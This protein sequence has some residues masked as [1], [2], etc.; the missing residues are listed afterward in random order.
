MSKSKVT[1]SLFNLLRGIGKTEEKLVEKIPEAAKTPVA[2]RRRITAKGSTPL[3]VVEYANRSGGFSGPGQGPLFL[4]VAE[5]VHRTPRGKRVFEEF[6]GTSL[7]EYGEFRFSTPSEMSKPF[8][9]RVP[10]YRVPFY[11]PESILLNPQ[12]Y[13]NVEFALDALARDPNLAQSVLGRTPRAFGINMLDAPPSGSKAHNMILDAIKASGD[14][15][16]SDV[17]SD[18]NLIRRPVN[19]QNFGIAH[20]DYKH[21]QPL[22][23]APEFGASA[24]AIGK[25]VGPLN[26][27][28][29][30]MLNRRAFGSPNSRDMDL[31]ATQE[32]LKGLGIDPLD[33]IELMK[34]DASDL[35]VM[36]VRDPQ[37]VTGYLG[38][39][40]ALRAA[41]LGPD[42]YSFNRSIIHPADKKTLELTQER[43]RGDKSGI[44]G[45]FGPGALGRARTVEAAVEGLRQ[46][47]TPDEIVE[48]ITKGVDPSGFFG[49][50]KHG[51]GVRKYK[52]GGL[53]AIRPPT[54]APV[55]APT[56]DP[57]VEM[58]M[59][60]LG[61]PAGGSPSPEQLEQFNEVYNRML[62]Q[63]RLREETYDY[64]FREHDA[65]L[66]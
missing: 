41:T 31:I 28:T 15:Y 36:G 45:A 42:R 32:Y 21:A 66:G 1:L 37:V 9:K 43:G 34:L 13:P 54:P 25:Q 55:E 4:D 44:P 5:Q 40:N 50:Y 60:Q 58:I 61:V 23:Y 26:Q 64:P 47:M 7:P 35:A 39:N 51:G 56:P 30:T 57:L 62:E 8:N 46:Q 12:D 11:E 59:R 49:R 24:E 38:L 65:V 52:A 53:S 29:S 48:E 22:S 19:V 20:G 2:D 33:A 17:L 18:R 6:K 16:T 14:L 27:V 3:D 10:G 63:R